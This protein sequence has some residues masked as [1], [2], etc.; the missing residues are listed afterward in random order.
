MKAA[1]CLYA[2]PGTLDEAVNLL[3]TYGDGASILAG[4]QSLMPGLNFRLSSPN[5]LV[6]INGLLQSA[7]ELGQIVDTGDAIR[8]GMLVR[9]VDIERSDLIAREFPM[10]A[11]AVAFV[12]HPAIRNRGTF[13]GSL[14]YADPAAEWPAVCVALNAVLTLV[15]DKGSRTI[16]AEDYFTGLFESQRLGGEIIE[17]V[18]IPKQG[19][20]RQHGFYELAR[21]HGDFALAGVCV[22]AA[23]RE[24]LSGARICFF[25]VHSHACLARQTMAL[26]DGKKF[27][28]IGA[29][30]VA[31]ALA[32]DLQPFD[33]IHATS[34][35]RLHLAKVVLARACE[36]MRSGGSAA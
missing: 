34:S 13:C 4:G 18:D 19:G 2:R 33:D 3:A 29:D 28:E 17:S 11:Q 16:A 22:D 31:A 10:I 12:A 25:G 24:K 7:P 20:K 21:R 14:A 1:D 35:Q 8:I 26:V 32:K 5:V 30:I 36:A 6:D 9:H 27:A 15:S 23:G